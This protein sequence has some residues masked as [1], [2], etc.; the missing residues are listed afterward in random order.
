MKKSVSYE[1]TKLQTEMVITGSCC[2][3][4]CSHMLKF[5]V[6]GQYTIDLS[7][8]D[9]SAYRF[10]SFTRLIYQVPFEIRLLKDWPI[11]INQ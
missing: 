5:I 10:P 4:I 1:K 2:L 11:L 8:S 9:Q 7:E 3:E 6:I